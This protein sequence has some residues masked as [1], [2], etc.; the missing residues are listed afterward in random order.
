VRGARSARGF[1]LL[2]ILVVVV[3]I[4][5]MTALGVLSIGVLGGDRQIEGE[6][7]RFTD[8]VQTASEEAE[9]EGRDFGI[10]ILPDG[11]KVY[12]YAGRRQRWEELAEDRLYEPHKLPA[13]INV[14]LELEGK[15]VLIAKPKPGETPAPQITLYASGE[16]APYRLTLQRDATPPQP[17][18][19]DGQADATIKLTK[20]EAKP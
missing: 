12:V 17:W 19:L 2:E 6:V 9:L 15:P 1:T 8:L 18:I 5:I 7:D 16:A 4:A 14:Y 10:Q 11:Y 20:P 13:G 3:I